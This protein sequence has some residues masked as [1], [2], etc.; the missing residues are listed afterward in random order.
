MDS[1][2]IDSVLGNFR[3]NA[4]TESSLGLDQ[5]MAPAGRFELLTLSFVKRLRFTNNLR[6]NTLAS[7]LEW[8]CLM[9]SLG[10][11]RLASVCLN[12][13]ACW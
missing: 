2:I 4:E 8:A 5:E 13:P 1:A 12:E 10:Q 3:T 6:R 9:H 7:Y 11:T